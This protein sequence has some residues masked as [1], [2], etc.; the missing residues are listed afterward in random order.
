MNNFERQ[1]KQVIHFFEQR[2]TDGE[3][4]QIDTIIFLIG[5]QELNMVKTKF[6]K[7]E[8]LNLMHIAICKLL[9]PYGYYKFSHFDNDRWPH[10]NKENDIEEM[11]SQEQEKLIKKAIINYFDDNKLI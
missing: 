2:F 4:P 3:K 8:K 1:W 7:D 11:A 5:V 6:T 9:E 10:Y